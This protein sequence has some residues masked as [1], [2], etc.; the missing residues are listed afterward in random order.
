MKT[1]TLTDL[2][3][4][5]KSKLDETY[6]NHDILIVG[7]KDNKDMVIMALEDYESLK[8]TAY[9]LST[10]ANAERLTKSMAQAKSKELVKKSMLELGIG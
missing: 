6:E 9:L 5:L 1:T 10:P 4:N 2:R 8:E 3:K 7:R